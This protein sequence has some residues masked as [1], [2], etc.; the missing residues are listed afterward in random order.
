MID[1]ATD[2]TY[3]AYQ[4]GDSERLRIRIEAHR[5]YSELP[6]DWYPLFAERLVAAPG[7]TVADVGCGPG[8]IQPALC[9]AGARVAGVDRSAGMVREALAQARRDGLPVQVLQ[10]DAQALPFPDGQ[11]DGALAAH[12][13]Y[14]VPD[15]ARA[16]RELRRVVKP[17]GHVLIS[18]NASDHSE[19]LNAFHTQA[20]RELGYTPAA[21]NP[22]R[23]FSLDHLPLVQSVFPDVVLHRL[24]NAFIFPTT[25]AALAYYA[26][27]RVDSIA[28]RSPDG[29]HRAPLIA[30]VGE[31][32][33]EIV[34]REGAFRV[35][36][37][38]GFFLATVTA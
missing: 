23:R 37:D 36:K 22:D 25:K 1:R 19:R 10:A 28:E 38:A 5:R 34:A 14:H 16:L 31:L 17:G 13:L 8:N 9:A 24:P 35:P 26:S 3:L 20:A 15:I 2:P 33:A 30:R 27:G 4:Y 32:I 12:M 29:S 7:V 21:A 18:T 6:T 11:F